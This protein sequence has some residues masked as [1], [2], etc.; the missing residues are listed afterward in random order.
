VSAK[1][2]SIL[3]LLFLL[4]APFQIA[5]G[6]VAVPRDLAEAQE[7]LARHLS[8]RDIARF[9]AMKS[10]SEIYQVVD[11]PFLIWFTNEWGLWGN[12]PLTRYFKRLGVTQP[13]DMVGI[14]AQT[15]WCKLHGRPF[16]LRE[17]IAFIRGYYAE[18]E[19]R[20]PRSRS[21]RD[22][23]EIDWRSTHQGDDG[24]LYLGISRSDGSF[25]RYDSRHKSRGIEPARRDEREELDFIVKLDKGER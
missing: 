25:W 12:P 23:A 1:T 14:V 17:K 22:G 11:I 5:T 9:R 20:A 13:H 24:N 2:I 3:T 6:D 10:E 8:A 21:P 16:R 18:Q 19:A 15:Y 4:I 7:N